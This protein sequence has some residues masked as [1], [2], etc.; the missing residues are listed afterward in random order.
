MGKVRNKKMEPHGQ[1]RGSIQPPLGGD[2]PVK[3]W[4]IPPP[5]QH[6]GGSPAAGMMDRKRSTPVPKRKRSASLALAYQLTKSASR[7][8]FDWPD[9]RGVL[10]KL[11]E[12]LIEFREALRHRDQKR[13]QEELGDLLFVLANVARFLQINPEKALRRTIQKFLSR[14]HY[15]EASLKKKGKSLRQSN[16]IEMDRLWEEAKK[17]EKG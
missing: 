3:R 13:A 16:L 5:A 11:D 2:I 8:G 4:R 9:I 12:E 10:R 7:V 14:F 15:V 6:R 1:A 17:K